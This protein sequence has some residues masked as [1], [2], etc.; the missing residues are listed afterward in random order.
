M[1]HRLGTDLVRDLDRSCKQANSLRVRG[2]KLEFDMGAYQVMA[3]TAEGVVVDR[4]ARPIGG[5][6]AKLEMKG[7]L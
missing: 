4:L 2:I 3:V 5:K 7:E 6:L 1:F